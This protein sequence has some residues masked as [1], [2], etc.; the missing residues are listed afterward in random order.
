VLGQFAGQ[1]F[2]GVEDGADVPFV[3][4]QNQIRRQCIRDDEY[5]LRQ[6]RL[7]RNDTG[8]R[9]LFIFLRGNFDLG[10]FFFGSR[11]SPADTSVKASNDLI[12]LRGRHSDENGNSIPKKD[13]KGAGFYS[14]GHGR[15][16]QDVVPLKA[17]R[18]ETV[19]E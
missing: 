17:R 12:L 2:S 13:N 1:W 10:G 9:D 14:K 19:T 7:Q 18:I 3:V 16:R 8:W 5:M 15:R 11:K 6:Q 4:R